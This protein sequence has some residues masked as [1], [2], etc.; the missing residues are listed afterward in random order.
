MFSVQGIWYAN[1]LMTLKFFFFSVWFLS[2]ASYFFIQLP[3]GHHLQFS[4]PNLAFSLCLRLHSP[5]GLLPKPPHTHV[6]FFTRFSSFYNSSLFSGSSLLLYHLFPGLLQNFLHFLTDAALH[7]KEWR[8]LLLV[9][10]IAWGCYY[11]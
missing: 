2:W 6:C 7:A 9:M 4:M 5:F 8:C 10:S 3:L 1:M 11:D